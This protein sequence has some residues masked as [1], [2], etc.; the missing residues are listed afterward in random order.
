MASKRQI[1]TASKKTLARVD[2][3]LRELVDLLAIRGWK[4]SEIRDE[5]EGTIGKERTPHL[6]WIQRR[7][8]KIRPKDNS[9]P[10]LFAQEEDPKDAALILSV[11]ASVVGDE[12]SRWPVTNAE[13]KWIVRICR[14]VPDVPLSAV[15]QIVVAYMAWERLKQPT[16]L[17]DLILAVRPWRSFEAQQALERTLAQR[18]ERGQDAIR[19][20]HRIV[21][22]DVLARIRE[23]AEIEEKERKQRFIDDTYMDISRQSKEPG[24][25]ELE[26]PQAMR[27]IK[28][29]LSATQWVSHAAI[30]EALERGSHD[31]GEDELTS[32]YIDYLYGDMIRRKE[33]Q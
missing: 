18:G 8:R 1:S 25:D 11:L 24:G 31:K 27:L 30:R 29:S 17:L 26:E 4:A 22:G 21:N 23:I 6:R 19:V 9:G 7:V 32:L 15:D 10:W 14:A 12:V 3:E 28:A 2:G 13:A 5:L 20:I 16:D 33:N